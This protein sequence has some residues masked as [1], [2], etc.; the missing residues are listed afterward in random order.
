M[1][2]QRAGEGRGL[3]AHLQ[4]EAAK[5]QHKD[6]DKAGQAQRQADEQLE[7]QSLPGRVVELLSPSDGA[8]ASD[9]LATSRRGSV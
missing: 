7:E 2:G 6:T 5:H 1:G 9:T 3:W 4:L 8:D